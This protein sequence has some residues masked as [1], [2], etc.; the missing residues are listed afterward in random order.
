MATKNR[1][2]LNYLRAKLVEGHL[3]AQPA[4]VI[5]LVASAV[6]V[7]ALAMTAPYETMKGDEPTKG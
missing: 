3:S 5:P 4:H 6:V 1:S 2:S 7:L